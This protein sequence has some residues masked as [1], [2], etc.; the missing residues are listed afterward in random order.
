[1]EKQSLEDCGGGVT[2]WLGWGWAADPQ[3]LAPAEGLLCFPAVPLP[4]LLPLTSTFLGRHLYVLP[5][6]GVWLAWMP[7]WSTTQSIS[8]H[9]AILPIVT[10]PLS[11]SFAPPLISPCSL[12]THCILWTLQ[13]SIHR[14]RRNPG[15]RIWKPKAG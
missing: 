5:L 3:V 8:Q 12:P 13:A 4:L 9:G 10:T 6:I 1:M 15:K 11:L 7:G 2:A 14:A